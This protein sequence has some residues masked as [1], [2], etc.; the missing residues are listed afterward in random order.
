MQRHW[1][2]LVLFLCSLILCLGLN[3]ACVLN[4]SLSVNAAQV[5]A[6][7]FVQQGIDR[8]QV[9][10]FR[11]AIELW[12]TALTQYQKD[13]ENT[14]IVVEN[15]ARAY[16]QLGQ[17]ELEIEYWQRAIALNRQLGESKHVAQLLTEIA[18]TYARSGQP[19]TAIALLCN[20]N[21][22]DT[23][24]SESALSLARKTHDPTTE[25]A[26]L[27]SL[28]E[29]YRLTGNYT[30][31][32]AILRSG[33]ERGQHQPAY[34]L[35]VYM[36]L[37]S[38]HSSLARV[39]YRRAES[40]EQ[41]GDTVEAE[42]LR[43]LG[44]TEDLTALS[45]FQKSLTIAQTLN[46]A[47]A[48]VRA[49]L[50]TIPAHYRLDNINAAN[51]ALQQAATQLTTLP[52]SRDRVYAEIELARLLQPSHESAFQTACLAPNLVEK[53]Q[54]LLQSAVTIAAQIQDQRASSFALGELGHLYEC[55][56]DYAQAL[57]LT[58][59]ARWAA[60]QH[61]NAKDSL[62]LW[63]WQTGRILK[64]QGD[65][66]GAISLYDR[67]IA[68][69]DDIRSDIL[70][71]DRDVRFDFRDTVEPV[72]RELISLR[73]ESELLTQNNK[74]G[75]SISVKPD[76]DN[77]TATLKA[78]DSLR[79][80]ELQNYF[81]ND[82]VLTVT[83]PENRIQP[84]LDQSTATFSS[85]LLNDRLAIVL[86][87]PN[88]RNRIAFVDVSLSQIRQ[89]V[90]GFRR[91]LERF[92]DD[93]DPSQAQKLYDWIVRPFEAELAPIKTL[94]FVQ[95]G[96][97]R[98]IPMAALYDGQKFLIQRYAIATTPSLQLTEFKAFDRQNLRAL[99][100]GLTQR[101]TVDGRQFQ[102]L[103][104]VTEEIREVETQIPGSKQL[105]DQ[106]FTRDQLQQELKQHDYSIIH[107]ATHGEFAADPENTFLV[108][109]NNQKL[110]LNELDRLIRSTTSR[111]ET[112][113]LLTLTACQTAAG[114]DRAALGLA[115]VAVQA[116][117]KSAIAS[118]WFI[119][120]AA[121]AQ[122]ATD[123]YS[124]LHQPNTTKAQALQTAQLALIES[125][126]QFSHPAYWAPFV[127]VG[128]WQ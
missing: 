16:Q 92:Y 51:T 77:L 4:R 34:A 38:T 54:T 108:M 17:R 46:D 6:D 31:A 82:C 47:K 117:A 87:L 9:G 98:T 7:Q 121:T 13:R 91:G 42:R 19:K 60:E 120:D 125:G 124:H 8:Y 52:K 65:R 111:Q 28:G 80:S 86:S 44:R 14:A 113:E 73:L 39:Q 53:A 85:I 2:K 107:I 101:A 30:T 67:A 127:L 58:E 56:G 57:A 20:G 88:H 18:Q 97:L 81:G 78:M 76:N 41:R 62:Y 12:Q 119:N 115:G 94:V 106:N 110:T 69:L 33:L 1:R 116:G 49:L 3:Q 100:L 126:G 21:E 50:N 90:N 105:L 83:T 89:E 112:I 45:Y 61:L 95:D 71:A 27:G 93:Y 29:A 24:T 68:T 72:Y 37:G 123:L 32:I 15:I 59:K 102:A 40:A 11:S 66:L 96:I 103:A 75:R 35:S 109:G 5:N 99:A 104:N 79:L 26:A 25:A 55:R 10:E 128:N 64:A 74:S 23:C 36:S 84:S 122:L 63:E 70:T 48:Q 22:S 43:Q 118:L 114:D